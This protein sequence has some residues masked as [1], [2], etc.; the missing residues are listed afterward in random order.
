MLL[1][2]L[3]GA[4]EAGAALERAQAG[5]WT[6]GLYNRVGPPS[7]TAA[8]QAPLNLPLPTDLRKLRLTNNFWPSGHLSG[9]M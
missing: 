4:R 3:C 2:K 7:T 9:V 8:D 1:V 6:N 5:N